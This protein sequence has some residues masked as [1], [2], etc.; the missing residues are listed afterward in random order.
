[1]KTKNVKIK[2]KDIKAGVTAYIAH[3]FL[4]I[5]KVVFTSRPY[6]GKHS[7][8]PRANVLRVSELFV[9][10]VYKSEVFLGDAGI[11]TSYN[12]RRTFFKLKHA[13]E[14]VRKWSANPRAIE[15]HNDHIEFCK[16][17]DDYDYE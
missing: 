10:K 6:V 11:I 3:P 1:M 12:D 16:S 7:E 5:D 9:G 15:R 2:P 8:F 14:W 13:E 17:M 4:G